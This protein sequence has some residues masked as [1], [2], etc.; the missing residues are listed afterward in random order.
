VWKLSQS[1]KRVPEEK[2]GQE[3]VLHSF[4]DVCQW[5]CG[6]TRCST[7]THG[8]MSPRG[9]LSAV[10]KHRTT[11]ICT[12]LVLKLRQRDQFMSVEDR[13]WHLP[14]KLRKHRR[15]ERGRIHT[16]HTRHHVRPQD[17]RTHVRA[18]HSVRPT[19]GSRHVKITIGSRRHA[20]ALFKTNCDTNP[21]SRCSFSPYPKRSLCRVAA[22]SSISKLSTLIYTKN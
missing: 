4:A 17:K 21:T 3:V 16:R 7:Y 12:Q 14:G 9:T 6:S 18:L 22:P 13:P 5:V 11:E 15:T 1:G 8:F 19:S 10:N 20:A 2:K